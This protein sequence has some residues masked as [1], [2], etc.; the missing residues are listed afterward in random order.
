ME[1]IA[2]KQQ[3]LGY[4][5]LHVLALTGWYCHNDCVFFSHLD[6]KTVSKASKV[7][8]HDHGCNDANG[9][10]WF[11]PPENFGFKH[12]WSNKQ[13]DPDVQRNYQEQWLWSFEPTKTIKL[14]VYNSWYLMVFNGIWLYLT[15]VSNVS[16]CLAILGMIGWS[17]RWRWLKP[18]NFPCEPSTE[19]PFY[20]PCKSHYISLLTCV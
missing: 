4:L 14:L 3:K 11:C 9:G 5:V 18:S 1:V 17:S 20:N 8:V 7:R 10:C 12:L 2:M 6:R 19:T 16:S 15:G 13:W